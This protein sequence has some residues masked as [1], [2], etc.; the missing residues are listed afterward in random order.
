MTLAKKAKD[1]AA[2][3]EIATR[4]GNGILIGTARVADK[5]TKA[6]SAIREQ[7]VAIQKDKSLSIGER[8]AKLKANEALQ[9]QIIRGALEAI[10][11]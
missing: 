3:T 9:Q 6:L 1:P 2:I 8:R 10:E 4:E 11:R 7:E 5:T